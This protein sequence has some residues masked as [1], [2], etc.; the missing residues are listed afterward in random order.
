MIKWPES[1]IREIAERRVIPFIGAGLSKTA[2]P[3]LPGWGN[4][5]ELLAQHLLVAKD[6]KLV[7]HLVRTQR[8][9][10]AAQIITDGIQKPDL[11][12]KIREV[13]QI[14]PTPHHQLYQ[15]ILQMDPKTIVTT[16]YDEFLEK[17]FEFYSNGTISDSINRLGSSTL[18]NDLRSPIRAI[19][20]LHGCV[21]IPIE[22]VLGRESYFVAR[23]KNIGLFGAITAL[24]TVSTVL[25]IG[26][27]ISDPDIQLILE[28]INLFGTSDH[29]HYALVEKFEHAAIK[30]AMSQ[31]YNIAFLEY[32]R[33]DHGS[34]VTQLSA[35]KD[36][37]LDLRASRGIV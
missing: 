27:S 18:I 2:H 16:N 32:P 17:N 29:P 25:F 8:L 30:R 7:G 21:T 3:P 10:D 31:T 19:V 20:K 36:Q 37:V 33:A 11:G 9:L 26:Y 15:D 28:N 14:G 13:F 4:L 6:R 23:K 5:L 24:M 1:L 12:A 22:V 35:L 34:V